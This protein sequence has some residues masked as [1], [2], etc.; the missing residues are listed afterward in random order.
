M[1]IGDGP[2]TA[3]SATSGEETLHPP[4]LM[5]MN[6]STDDL[7]TDATLFAELN[8]HERYRLAERRLRFFIYRALENHVV[9][10]FVVFI[11]SIWVNWSWLRT[12]VA[13]N[14]WAVG[15]A[16][17]VHHTRFLAT[18]P[19]LAAA[20]AFEGFLVWATYHWGLSRWATIPGFGTFCVFFSV[21]RYWQRGERETN[22][23]AFWAYRNLP[24]SNRATRPSKQGGAPPSDAPAIPRGAS[25]G[26]EARDL[27]V[28][29]S[30]GT[31]VVE[32]ELPIT[33]E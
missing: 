24:A 18:M 33:K 20:A 15:I 28:D 23:R 10:S 1:A 30:F 5:L 14:T 3:G 13:I 9:I 21:A 22:L 8:R 26:L 6:E 7:I 16:G 25:L 19:W 29:E 2:T 27:S 12:L 11:A 17:L 32:D 31:E 4:N